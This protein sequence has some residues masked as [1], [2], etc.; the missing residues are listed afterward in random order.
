MYTYVFHE[1]NKIPSAIFKFFLC[2]R[3]ERAHTHTRT[4]VCGCV[5]VC[6]VV[7]VRVTDKI[8]LVSIGRVLCL[9]SWSGASLNS[10]QI[11]LNKYNFF[12]ICSFNQSV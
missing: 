12:E 3:A 5:C 9:H 11:C 8:L 10:S 7:F 4:G 2:V 1:I 6:E